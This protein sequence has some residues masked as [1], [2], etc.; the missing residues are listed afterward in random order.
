MHRIKVNCSNVMFEPSHKCELHTQLF[1]NDEIEII[2][3]DVTWTE[4]K[5]KEKKDKS[6]FVLSSHIEETH[7]DLRYPNVLVKNYVD[8]SL[9]YLIKG[10]YLPQEIDTYTESI[11]SMEWTAYKIKRILSS[12]L[13]TGYMWGGNTH[14]GIDCS[15]LSRMLY[16]HYGIDLPH[17]ASEQIEFGT[18]VDF[19]QDAK[20]GDLAFLDNKEG[21][22]IHVG[23]LLSSDNII[24]ASERNGKVCIDLFDQEGIV[25]NQDGSRLSKL[26]IIKR[27]KDA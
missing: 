13:N 24:H 14:S 1:L 26:R 23:I 11:S 8:E 2:N 15:G 27:I 7:T 10:T 16:R 19:I 3:K 9:G 21:D 4:I 22:I 5:L 20:A 17:Y 6:Y 12:Y 25:S 18:V